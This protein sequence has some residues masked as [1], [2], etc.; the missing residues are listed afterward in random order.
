MGPGAKVA[1]LAAVL[2]GGLALVALFVSGDDDATPDAPPAAL[3]A[4]PSD[5]VVAPAENSRRATASESREPAS[6]DGVRLTGEV[7]DDEETPVPGATVRAVRDGAIVE[8]ARTGPDG[9]FT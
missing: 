3:I 8:E 7:I 6:S 4:S 5:V 9:R 2:A 1:L